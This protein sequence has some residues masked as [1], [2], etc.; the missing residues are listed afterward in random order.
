[1]PPPVM[2]THLRATPD[3]PIVREWLEFSDQ[4][5]SYLAWTSPTMIAAG[6]S[7]E[8]S[9]YAFD[10]D[11]LATTDS[12]Y[13]PD[14]AVALTTLLEP[15]WLRRA[16][17]ATVGTSARARLRVFGDDIEVLGSFCSLPYDHVRSHVKVKTYRLRA[18]FDQPEDVRE[19]SFDGN[20]SVLA[21]T[22]ISLID[23]MGKLSS[24]A[25]VAIDIPT[26][27]E[28]AT[29]SLIAGGLFGP[30]AGSNLFVGAWTGKA[31]TM[32]VRLRA[33]G[34]DIIVGGYVCILY[35]A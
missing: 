29:D 34:G 17:Y 13:I 3:E 30:D 2:I 35:Y 31:S 11:G 19:I 6:G 9:A 15:E 32:T 10:I 1:M 24:E 7:F 25:A 21:W 12:S 26:V 16:A 28:E 8:Q 22:G 23:P 5:V 14:Y 20:A 18:A 4:D 27:D 33:F